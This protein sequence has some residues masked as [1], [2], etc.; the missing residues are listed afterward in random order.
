MHVRQIQA[1][2]PLFKTPPLELIDADTSS[3]SK[4]SACSGKQRSLPAAPMT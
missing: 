2:A 3:N 1:V 4:V